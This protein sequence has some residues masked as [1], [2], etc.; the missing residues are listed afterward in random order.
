[1]SLKQILSITLLSVVVNA[2]AQEQNV[3]NQLPVRE[4]GYQQCL[5]KYLYD[6]Y[7]DHLDLS[8]TAGST[9]IG[10]DL[11]LPV[12]SDFRL[13]LGGAFMPR[14]NYTMH[15]DVLVGGVAEDKYDANGNRI[16]TRFDR[17]A[18]LLESMTGNVVDDNIDMIGRPS[19]YNAKVLADFFPL[20]NKNFHLTAG[21]YIGNSC[22][23]TAHNSMH[24]MSSLMA[25]SIYNNMYYRILAEEPLLEYN[26]MSAYLP[27][28]FTDRVRDYGM[29]SMPIGE[30]CRDVI[31]KEDVFYDHNEIDEITGEIIH[32]KGDVRV[33][34]GE[35]L[36]HR[37]E[38]YNMLPDGDNTVTVK[39]K[40]WT[41]K[42]YIGI[43]Y[44][45]AISRD[46][47]TRLSFDAGAMF[48]GGKPRMLTHE[49]VDLVHD[50]TQ[51]GGK[52]GDYVN[53]ARQFP[54]FP[55]LE[56]RLSHRLF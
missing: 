35:I 47:R 41:V 24:D 31:A 14:F 20:Q 18:G 29:M 4:N 33:A 22:F 46:G 12:G 26:G 38:T 10:F 5:H 11:A 36:Y 37:G 39:A 50:L 17:L 27:S 49:G 13:R 40:S 16:E 2:V 6:G 54:V 19:M 9:G 55:I 51:I 8:L 56:I 23:A 25:V 44:G 32:A 42:P 43:G 21:A 7:F 53:L 1:M 28:E 45:G 15:F 48:W 3:E 34:R 30:F 52:V